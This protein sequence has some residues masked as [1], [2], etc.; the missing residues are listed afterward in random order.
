MTLNITIIAPWGIWQ[1]TDARLTRWPDARYYEDVSIKHLHVGCRDGSALI[2]YAGWG[3][4]HDYSIADWLRR[5][6]RGDSLTLD[7]T[8]IRIRERATLKLGRVSVKAGIQHTFNIGAFLAGRPWAIV[9]SNM[10]PAVPPSITAPPVAEFNTSALVIDKE[11]MVLVTGAGRDAIS[12]DDWALLDKISK[13]RPKRSVDYR[14]VLVGINERAA[15]DRSAAGKSVS[16]MCTTSYMPPEGIPIEAEVHSWDSA[17][18]KADQIVPSVHLGI[19]LTETMQVM[20]KSFREIHDDSVDEVTRRA[21]E[22]RFKREYEEAAKRSVK[23]AF[24]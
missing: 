6:I 17:G 10:N 4:I 2:A 11:P 14:K 20:S 12:K 8:L 16:K 24:P 15:N 9:I 21:A 23:R 19:D 5:Q 7:E 18:D 3:K 1:C 22:E 13:R